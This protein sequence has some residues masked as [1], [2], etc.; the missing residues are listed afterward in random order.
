MAA[1]RHLSTEPGKTRFTGRDVLIKESV[2]RAGGALIAQRGIAMNE[3]MRIETDFL[4]KAGSTPILPWTS[5]K[6]GTD[7]TAD[8]VA[9]TVDG[10]YRFT[11]G[12]TSEAQTMRLDWGDQLLVPI[13][14]EPRL[15]CRIKP[16][17][18][19]ANYGTTT[20][21]VVGFA[22][23]YNATLGSITYNAWFKLGGH[24]DLKIYA[25]GDDNATDTNDQDSGAL[26]VAATY[27]TLEVDI[28]SAQV[29]HFLVDGVEKTSVSLAGASATQLLQPMI[30]FQRASGTVLDVANI[31]YAQVTWKRS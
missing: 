15:E 10:V 16:A 23:A 11:C 7:E 18:A 22:S 24:A 2:S 21:L 1:G 19:G 3:F 20:V 14:K 17:P 30:A 4:Q 6:T 13:G 28:D 25:E 31:D 27:L 9:N 12:G 26:W 5:T 8:F 29:A